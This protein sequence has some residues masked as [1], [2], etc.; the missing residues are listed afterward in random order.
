MGSERGDEHKKPCSL[1]EGTGTKGSDDSEAPQRATASR[2]VPTH[3]CDV[4]EGEG[5]RRFG[6]SRDKRPDCV[7][8]V[9]ALIVTPEGFPLGYE[10]LPGNT[11][12]SSTLGQMLEKIEAQYGRASRLWLMDRGIPT[13]AVLEQMR[14]ADPPVHYLVGT[15]KGRLTRLEARLAEKSWQ[16]VR[17]GV[18]VKLID[19]DDE[20]YVLARSAAR[21]SKERGMRQRRLKKLWRRLHELKAQ[22]L[23]YAPLLL[24]LGA[25][26]AKAGEAWKLVEICLPEPPA[27]LAQRKQPVSFEFTLNKQRLRQRRAREGRYLLRTNLSNE[28]PG[29]LW[30]HY[31]TLSQIEEAFRNLKGDLALRP[32]FHQK[33]TRVEAHIFIAFLAYCLHITLRRRLRDLAPGLTPRA[34]LEKFAT[35]S[36][37]DVHLPTSDGRMLV[38]SRHTQPDEECRL[39]LERLHLQLPAQPPPRI[40]CTSR[41]Q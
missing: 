24:K 34:V 36:M 14:Q 21:I 41:L 33:D 12:D 31:M 37:I 30:Q 3:Q 10:A 35:I 40:S 16:Q 11:A 38:L 17:E 5:L 39:L 22:R 28:D 25:A 8:V 27:S 18:A 29:A 32:V 9:I 26:K 23:A 7:Q 20:L 1:G 2:L 15:P 4:P 6:Y 13:E 19:E